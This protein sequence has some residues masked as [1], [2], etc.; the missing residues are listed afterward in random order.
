MRNQSMHRACANRATVP[1]R[2]SPKQ[3]RRRLN[4]DLSPRTLRQQGAAHVIAQAKEELARPSPR[5]TV[6]GVLKYVRPIERAEGYQV[7]L[8][9]SPSPFVLPPLPPLPK[10]PPRGFEP[11]DPL[12]RTRTPVSRREASAVVQEDPI[13]E[14]YPDYSRS[15]PVSHFASRNGVKVATPFPKD[16]SWLP[17]ALD[18]IQNVQ[19]DPR[20]TTQRGAARVEHVLQ[21][22]EALLGLLPKAGESHD[23]HDSGRFRERAR[24]ERVALEERGAGHVGS[25]VRV[26]VGHM[27]E[28]W[29]FLDGVRVDPRTSQRTC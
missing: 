10:S 8:L 25:H 12:P 28:V 13:R 24:R 21:Q 18:L 29:G 16:Q 15:K 2:I 14:F 4:A 26:D 19:G 5:I 9:S 1:I 23:L 7:C 27:S 3:P 6:T 20:G 22:Q 17:Q 11:S